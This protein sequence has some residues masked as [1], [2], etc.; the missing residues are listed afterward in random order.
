MLIEENSISVMRSCLEG[1][2]NALGDLF[3]RTEQWSWEGASSII[4]KVKVYSL[5]DFIALR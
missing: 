2:L 5:F 4:A 3:R 1:L